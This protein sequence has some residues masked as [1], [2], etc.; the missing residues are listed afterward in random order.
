[1][2][3]RQ[4]ALN[5]GF[6]VIDNFIGFESCD[7]VRVGNPVLSSLSISFILFFNSGDGCCYIHMFRYFKNFF[8]LIYPLGCSN[9]FSINAHVG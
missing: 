6:A 1:M 3:V 7:I 4:S 2:S 5:I 8:L 9:V